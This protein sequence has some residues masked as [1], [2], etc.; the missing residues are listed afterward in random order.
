M[1]IRSIYFYSCNLH[2][3][4]GV[5]SLLYIHIEYVDCGHNAPLILEINVKMNIQYKLPLH[6]NIIQC[7]MDSCL[8]GKKVMDT[9][10][11]QKREIGKKEKPMIPKRGMSAETFLL[12]LRV[13]P[14]IHTPQNFET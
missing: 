12:V 2:M 3:P 10:E 13:L 4:V 1:H 6:R 9:N 8:R 11:Q 7:Q 14:F 5:M